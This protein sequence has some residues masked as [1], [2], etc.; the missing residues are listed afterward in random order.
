MLLGNRSRTGRCR[1]GVKKLAVAAALAATLA[2][3]AA[4]AA[5][6]P[7]PVLGI[8]GREGAG[9]LAWFN[10]ASLSVLRGR[11]VLLGSHTGSVGILRRPLRC[12]RSPPRT[13]RASDSSTRARCAFSARSPCGTTPTPTSPGSRGRALTGSSSP[14]PSPREA[15]SRSSIRSAGARFAASSVTTIGNALAVPGGVALLLGPATGIGPAQLALVDADG[16]VRSVA[17]DRIQIGT[18]VAQGTGDVRH[19]RQA[20]RLR[21]RSRR[22]ARIRRRRRL[23]RRRGRPRH[24]R[25]RLPRAEHADAGEEHHRAVAPGGVARER[26][27]RRLRFRLQG[28]PRRRAGRTAPHRHA[29]LERPNGGRRRRPV[30]RRRGLARR[31]RTRSSASTGRCATASSSAPSS[32]SASRD[33]TATSAEPPR[34]GSAA[35]SSSER[36][37]RSAA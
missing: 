4:H 6:A 23:H 30:R 19:R 3:P 16:A 14:S 20:A 15:S 34:A 32:G 9:R 17:I 31:R 8:D 7:R 29:R 10:P 12:S 25:R 1:R 5:D 13:I 11:K 33:S 22:P 2:L 35:C 28:K 36:V 26:H 24:A 18:V 37:P 21:R 27:A